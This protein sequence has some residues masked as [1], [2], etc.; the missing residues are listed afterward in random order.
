MQILN[1]EFW[2]WSANSALSIQHSAFTAESLISIP[3]RNGLP[4][5]KSF[6]CL[7][8]RESGIVLAQKVPGTLPVKVA[9][10]FPGK[11]PATYSSIWRRVGQ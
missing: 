3:Q 2:N 1:A 8:R 4:K 9:G 11:V 10:T 7:S 6:Y 5:L